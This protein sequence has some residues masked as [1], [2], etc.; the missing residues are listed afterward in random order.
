MQKNARDWSVAV[1]HILTRA[2]I[3]RLL[4]FSL[5]RQVYIQLFRESIEIGSALQSLC[6]IR[7]N[8]KKNI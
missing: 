5:H 1:T 6:D 4:S 7:K 2:E 8:V 3:I